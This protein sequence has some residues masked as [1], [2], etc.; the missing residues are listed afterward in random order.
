MGLLSTLGGLAGSVFGPVGTSLG[1]ALGGALDSSDAQSSAESYSSAEAAK[2]R[3]FQERMSSTAYQRGVADMKA[4][5][6]NPMLA[7]SQGPAGVPGGSAA[8]Y[9]GA[10]GAQ[11][12]SAQASASSAA[13]AQ[14]QAETAASVGSATVGKIKQEI[15]NL[16]STNDQIKAV[17]QNLGEQ[18]QNLIREGY[19]L[20][21]TGN[22]LRAT[23]DKIRAEIP[24]VMTQEFKARIDAALSQAQAGNVAAATQLLGLDIKAA[25]AFDNLGR[26]ASQLKP[27]FDILRMFIRR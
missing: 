6:L 2:N 19:N 11:T 21:E 26:E 22:V 16:G 17:T 15:A 25:G 3:E 20:V 10:V 13:A 18:Y 9:P 27:F 4:A 24:L 12:V 5:G 14:S 7:Y 23:V 8:I 1:T